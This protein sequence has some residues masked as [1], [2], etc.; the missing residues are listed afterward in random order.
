ML[1]TM[2]IFN[3]IL[4]VYVDITMKAA[5]ENDAQTAEQYS[6][7]SVRVARTTRE[8]L[9]KFATAYHIYHS[10]DRGRKVPKRLSQTRMNM[11]GLYADV[12]DHEEIAI[13]KD[14]FLLIIQDRMVQ[15]LMDEL[16][17]RTPARSSEDS[18]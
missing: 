8:L 1:V 5:K 13:T 3:V 2:G 6:R 11:G 17:H 10:E 15:K 16:D 9:K 14:L 12:G 7:E 4:A 18:R